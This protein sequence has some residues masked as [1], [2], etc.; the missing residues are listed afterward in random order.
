IPLGYVPEPVK[1]AISGDQD[2]NP[3]REL[4]SQALRSLPA[5]V[6]DLNLYKCKRKRGPHPAYEAVATWRQS[7]KGRPLE[8]RALNLSI[9]GS[10][11]KDFGT[12]E[13]FTPI[14]LVMRARDC[15]REDAVAWLM[16]RLPSSGP[17]V[18]FDAII[19]APPLS[20]N[21]EPEPDNQN[22]GEERTNEQAKRRRFVLTP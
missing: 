18:D 11:I 21:G 20:E 12:G 17:D 2:E 5:W 9:V 1:P 6:L 14:D 15:T 19:D 22:E 3:F 16:D 8:Q 7:T 13:K 10:G 4:N